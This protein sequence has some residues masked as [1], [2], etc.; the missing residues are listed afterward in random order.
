MPIFQHIR[1][2]SS[3]EVAPVRISRELVKRYMGAASQELDAS[4]EGR[5]DALIESCSQLRPS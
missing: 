1:A 3:A 4:L 2:V 5:I